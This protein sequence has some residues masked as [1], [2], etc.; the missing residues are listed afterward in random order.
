MIFGFILAAILSA[1]AALPI[2]QQPAETPLNFYQ[3][4]DLLG[5]GIS[6]QRV[7]DLVNQKGISFPWLEDD[8]DL[9]RVAGAKGDL[10]TALRT[11]KQP[12]FTPLLALK[13]EQ[14]KAQQAEE[15]AE[16]AQAEQEYRG[17]LRDSPQNPLFHFMLG[18]ALQ[19]QG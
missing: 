13:P 19:E 2:P 8:A 17:A 18:R 16:G 14:L 9:L 11:A 4:V 12:A 3:I 15:H 1:G 5:R 6:D 7:I 10:I